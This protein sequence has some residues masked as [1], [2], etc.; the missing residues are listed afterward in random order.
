LASG[1]DVAAAEAF[2][3]WLRS[4][5]DRNLKGLEMESGGFVADVW[6]S[7]EQR[8]SLVLR[9]ISDYGDERKKQLEREYKGAIRRY[10]IHNA[11]Q[12]LSTILTTVGLPLTRSHGPEQ[13]KEQ[14]ICEKSQA[15]FAIRRKIGKAVS[16]NLSASNIRNSMEKYWEGLYPLAFMG[17][18]IN[19][20]IEEYLIPLI[21]ERINIEV[22][23]RRVYKL[24]LSED[25]RQ[26]LRSEIINLIDK[27]W[28]NILS[29]SYSDTLEYVSLKYPLFGEYK[30]KEIDAIYQNYTKRPPP[31][32]DGGKLFDLVDDW[33]ADAKATLELTI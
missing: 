23:I 32:S 4:R 20:R 33:L 25:R 24:Q 7:I 10:A 18:A 6:R 17:G 29:A 3:R 15:E 1:P 14:A 11:A 13:N 22:D 21:K 12:L 19:V 28:A 27:E 9:G 8:R 31:S 16:P 5:R 2:V 30:L 26:A